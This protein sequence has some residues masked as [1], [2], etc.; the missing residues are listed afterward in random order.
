MVQKAVFESNDSETLMSLENQSFDWR[1]SVILWG[2]E[3]SV[4]FPTGKAKVRITDYQ[5]TYVKIAANTSQPGFLVLSDAYYPGWTAYLN[6][7][8]VPILRANYAFRAVKLSAG[9]NILEFK[10]EPISLYLGSAITL[11]ASLFILS[12]ALRRK[13]AQ[14][15]NTFMLRGV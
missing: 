15:I 2:N 9:N 8:K 3:E 10:Y 7:A 12:S 4:K 5:P 11:I 14:M 1:S 6:G 13:K